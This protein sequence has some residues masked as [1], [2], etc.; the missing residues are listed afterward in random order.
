MSY[1]N[2]LQN[3]VWSFSRLGTFENCKYEFYLNYI[4]NDNNVYLREGNYFAEVGSFVHKILAMIYERKLSSEEAVYYYVDNFYKEVNYTTKK[5]IMDNTFKSCADFFLN[6]DF[7]WLDTYN[8]LGVEYETKFKI[9]TYNFIGYIDAFLGLKDDKT[10]ILLDNKSSRYPF[11]KN[12]KIKAN[13]RNNFEK[14]KKQ[15]YLY[16][17]GIRN[18]FDVFPK[19]MT[20][21]HFKDK[22]KFATIPFDKTEFDD[23]VLW[24]I[25]TIKKIENEKDFEPNIN[26][27]YCKNLCAFR[28]SCEYAKLL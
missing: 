8:V 14:Y 22:G 12:G 11:G 5:S 3:M 16:C 15:M 13:E 26:Y 7:S 23:T 17:Y 4:V 27:F 1:K 21:L 18:E 19:E 24:A 20:W 25:D 6:S 9:H 28:N 2:E 10:I